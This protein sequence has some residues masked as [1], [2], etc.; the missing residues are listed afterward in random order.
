MECGRCTEVCPAN[1]SGKNLNPKTIIT[2]ARDFSQATL[3][4]NKTDGDFWEEN[5]IYEA[6]ELDACTTC[7]ACMEECPS[8]IEHV[9]LIMEAKRYKTLTLGEI[10]PSA[11]D[12][13]NKIKINGN[14]WGISQD[15]RFKWAEG[16]DVPVIE[17]EKKVDY[18]YYVGCAGSYDAANQKVVQDTVSL[19]KK[20]QRRLCRYGKN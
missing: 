4:S 12:T 10:P 18:L 9:N 16:L 5:P 15:D 3:S 20:C 8:N 1:L 11:G 19:L 14:P 17:S 7:G 13:V 2:K 6:N